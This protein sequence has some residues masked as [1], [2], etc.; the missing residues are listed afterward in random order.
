MSKKDMAS[1]LDTAIDRRMKTADRTGIIVS[2]DKGA[3]KIMV[4]MGSGAPAA[5]TVPQ[6]IDISNLAV[7][8]SV[9]INTAS[10]EFILDG[11]TA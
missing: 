1:T 4:R 8:M 7:D 3:R 6:H 9:R 5:V 2:V 10:Q 11:V